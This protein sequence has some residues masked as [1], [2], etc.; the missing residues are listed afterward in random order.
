MSNGTANTDAVNLSQL[1][2]VKTIAQN[3]QTAANNASSKADQA[4]EKAESVGGSIFA[5]DIS[6]FSDAFHI[7]TKLLSMKTGQP[8]NIQIDFL[9]VN[10]SESEIHGA[11]NVNGIIQILGRIKLTGSTIIRLSNS[12]G[13][14]F[15]FPIIHY[16]AGPNVSQLMSNNPKET[17]DTVEFTLGTSSDTGKVY[18]G[19]VISGQ[20]GTPLYMYA[21]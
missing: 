5:C 8:I 12:S 20:E 3:A 14:S 19:I 11:Y 18:Q 2:G 7:T 21:P 6:T 17:A 9:K 1:N 10:M 4:L 15:K 13:H 16:Y